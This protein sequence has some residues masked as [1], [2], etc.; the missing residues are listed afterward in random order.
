MNATIAPAPGAHKNTAV[1]RVTT[2]SVDLS[3]SSATTSTSQSPT[4]LRKGALKTVTPTDIA[5]T[6]TSWTGA[7][8]NVG[9]FLRSIASMP[10][11]PAPR[12]RILT[13]QELESPTKAQTPFAAKRNDSGE[14]ALTFKDKTVEELRKTYSAFVI[15][16]KDGTQRKAV[17]TLKQEGN[18]VVV[19]FAGSQ[20]VE[21]TDLLVMQR[22]SVIGPSLHTFASAF[23]GGIANLAFKRCEHIPVHAALK[24]AKQTE[25]SK[26]ATGDLEG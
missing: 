20:K 10:S 12:V 23:L 16:S 13:G 7:I 4:E 1:G 14:I 26:D 17:G 25:P 3:T 24:G 5:Y 8:H 9:E 21:N 22:T 11:L 19:T 2:Q 18:S 15:T 6:S